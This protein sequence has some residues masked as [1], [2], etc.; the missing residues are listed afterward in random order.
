[1]LKDIEVRCSV[2][3]EEKD[4]VELLNIIFPN[5]PTVDVDS[6]L[7]YWFWK[8]RDN[9]VS[10][11]NFN[12][13]LSRGN[14]IGL[15]GMFP[16]ILK[17]LDKLLLSNTGVDVG[18]HPDY[19]GRGIYNHL[20]NHVNEM[21]MME[22][23]GFS[24]GIESNPI[25]I[26]SHERRGDQEKTPFTAREDFKIFDIGVHYQHKKT[27]YKWLKIIGFKLLNSIFAL[28]N[29]FHGEL[30]HPEIS[31]SEIK[32]FDSR[33]NG[34]WSTIKEEYDFIF[35]KTE[36]ILNWRYFDPRGGKYIVKIAEKDGEIV[37]YIVTSSKY[38][39]EYQVGYIVELLSLSEYPYLKNMLIKDALNYFVKKKINIIRI[40]AVS[41]N[42]VEKI[43]RKHFFIKG[44]PLYLTYTRETNNEFYIRARGLLVP[45]R[46]HFSYGDFDYI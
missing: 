30:K 28:K 16:S 39:R 11:K 13:A 9:P 45:D 12:V 29:R 46:I 35:K 38:N 17:I 10:S 23:Y 43:L 21:R 8:F 22:G 26:Q 4:I 36:D 32:I 15:F 41:N 14:M 2:E 42:T 6:P 34:F 37:G 19:R 27:N 25:L 44:K 7:E 18:I 40:L 31:I 1:M 5:W 3:G 24:F 33:I 20:R